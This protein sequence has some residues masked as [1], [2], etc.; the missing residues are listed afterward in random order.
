MKRTIVVMA[1]L[2]LAGAAAAEAQSRS[3]EERLAAARRVRANRV[4]GA[5]EG[6]GTVQYDTGSPTMNITGTSSAA[7][8]GNLFDTRNGQ[9]LSSGTV[10]RLSWYQGA[11]CPPPYCGGEEEGLSGYYAFIGVFLNPGAATG[12]AAFLATVNQ[13]A[14]NSIS[15]SVTV[16]GSPNFFVGLNLFPGGEPLRGPALF[17][18]VG[19]V[20]ATTNGQG[21]HG[22][23][24][25]WTGN[26][27]APLT[28]TNAVVRATGSIIIPVELLEF[29]VE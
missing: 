10:T 6:T 14:F 2:V 23:Q 28:A 3:L 29:E 11:G 20:T 18:S 8:V 22:H 25:D 7:Y 12:A 21:F 1:V 13:Y 5:V 24:R 27:S 9:P 16:S 15:V 26:N 4:S 17:G 19:A